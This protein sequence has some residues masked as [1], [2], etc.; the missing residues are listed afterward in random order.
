MSPMGAKILPR[1]LRPNKGKAGTAPSAE[2]RS[3]LDF[4]LLRSVLRIKQAF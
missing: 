3:A 2:P 4:D 1:K